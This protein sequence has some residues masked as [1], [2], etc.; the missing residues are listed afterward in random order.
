LSV[1]ATLLGGH[2][3]IKPRADDALEAVV[4]A[5]HIRE[6]ILIKIPSPAG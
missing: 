6:Q 1:V 3:K 5:S 4:K 2:A